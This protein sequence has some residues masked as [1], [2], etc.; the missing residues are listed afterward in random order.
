MSL[1]PHARVTGCVLVCRRVT[2]CVLMESAVRLASKLTAA[3]LS[4]SRPEE[5]RALRVLPALHSLKLATFM[6]LSP[7]VWCLPPSITSLAL[8]GFFLDPASTSRSALKTMFSRLPLLNT[9][10]V[11]DMPISPLLQGLLDAGVDALPRLHRVEFAQYAIDNSALFP[12]LLRRFLH[13]FSATVVRVEFSHRTGPDDEHFDSTWTLVR[14]FCRHPRVELDFGEPL[15][16][17]AS[18]D[19]SESEAELDTDPHDT[20]E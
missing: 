20:D 14:G 5:I 18:D 19:D 12:D 6:P 1:R 7:L 15:R 10:R 11:E 16:V 13:K 2:G 4:P 8:T 9:M 17:H 3:D